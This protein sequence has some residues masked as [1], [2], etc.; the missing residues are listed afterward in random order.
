M[1]AACAANNIASRVNGIAF[2]GD[3]YQ[4]GD[5]DFGSAY[6]AYDCCVACQTY[7]TNNNGRRCSFSLYDDNCL[8][9]VGL[10]PGTCTCLL[11]VGISPGTCYS[12]G[13]HQLCDSSNPSCFQASFS[14]G[15]YANSKIG[16]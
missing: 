5:L 13:P 12:G 14:N 10:S 16:F 3:A 4:Y 9:G 1:Y 6:S 2:N 11:G 8:M 7:E 15:C